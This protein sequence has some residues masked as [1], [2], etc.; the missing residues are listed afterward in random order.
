MNL[1]AQFPFFSH[2]K[3]QS[4]AYL[5]NAATTQKP[6]RVIERLRTYYEHQN[7]NVHRGV[8]K[9]SEEATLYFEGTR[10]KAAEFLQAPN[11]KDIVFSSGTT[12]SINLIAQSWGGMDLKAGDEILLPISE[13]HS[14]I[15]PWQLIAQRTGAILKFIPLNESYRL[16]V[17]AA[18]KLV[19]KRTK[20]IT[21][22]H[23]SNVLGIIHPIEQLIALAK[24]CGAISVI[25]GAQAIPHFDV[26]VKALDCDFYAFS[27]HKICGPTGVGVLYGKTKQL[28][29]MPPF[30]GGGDMISKVSISGSSWKEPPHRFEAGTPNIADIIA[31]GEAIDFLGSFDRKAALKADISLGVKVLE[32]LKTKKQVRLFTQTSKTVQDWVGIVPF[33]HQ[34]IHPHDMA[35]IQDAAGVCVR[36]GQH[37]AEPLMDAL[38]VSSTTRVSP[39]IYNNESDITRFMEAFEK[40]E[41]IFS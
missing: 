16:D 4:L 40:A 15:V 14:N 13:H 23:V 30:L 17:E 25:D 28:A 33:F 41:N 34:V 29:S 5:D 20:I 2:P 27:S 24:D 26:D 31:M 38:G 9:L 36:A 39:Y 21:M 8:Y 18:Q 10:K 32:F 22:A 11:T 6:L 35:A 1:R 37:C 19:S 3:T 7:A 12:A